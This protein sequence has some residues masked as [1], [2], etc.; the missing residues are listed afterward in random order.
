MIT[1]LF[2]NIIIRIGNVHYDID[3]SKIPYLLF[4]IDFQANAQS[5]STELVHNPIPLFDI[6]LKGIESNYYQCFHSLSANLSQ[7]CILCDMY[8]FLHVDIFG[9]QSINEIFCDLKSDQSDYDCEEKQ[10][11]KGDKSKVCDTVFKLLCLILLRDFKN[12]M[13]DNIKVF[14]AVLYVVSHAVTFK[15]RMRSV[16]QTVYEK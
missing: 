8:N 16:V 10:E 5:Q 3:V 2:S 15:W 7:H 6:A 11:I 4:F 9:R 13:Q 12:E 14:N 1:T